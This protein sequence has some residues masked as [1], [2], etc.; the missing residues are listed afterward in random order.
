M[1]ICVVIL[2][3][4]FVDHFAPILCFYLLLDT[5]LQF[6]ALLF[7]D[8]WAPI[9]CYTVW[10]PL[11]SNSVFSVWWPLCSNSVLYCFF[12]IQQSLFLHLQ[13]YRVYIFPHTLWGKRHCIQT[14][15]YKSEV[16]N[17]CPSIWL[18]TLPFIRLHIAFLTRYWFPVTHQQGRP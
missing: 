6:C 13:R 7:G 17:D 3:Y 4:T 2:C 9:L 10:W 11:C 15:Q 12:F 8:H 16:V 1:T 5:V 14:F 18:Y